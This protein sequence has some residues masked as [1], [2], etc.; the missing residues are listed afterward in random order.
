MGES[1]MTAA[2]GGEGGGDAGASAAA[3]SVGR[4]LLVGW[5]V[6]VSSN[7]AVT[8]EELLPVGTGD[9]S[10]IP[11]VIVSR[12]L[13]CGGEEPVLEEAA[14][15]AATAAAGEGTLVASISCGGA[16]ARILEGS[17]TDGWLDWD[18][19]DIVDEFGWSVLQVPKR[20]KK[21]VGSPVVDDGLARRD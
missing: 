21:S 20:T 15:A 17:L 10:F 12:D 5:G 8:E 1:M 18:A 7:V 11:I 16:A 14:S 2:P 13:W 3:L 6:G 9:P 4:V 19:V